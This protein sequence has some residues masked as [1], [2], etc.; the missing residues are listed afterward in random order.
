MESSGV[1]IKTGVIQRLKANFPEYNVYK[2]AI[3]KPVFPSFFIDI[4]NKTIQRDS[5]DRYFYTE[6]VNI[7]IRLGSD[8]TLINNINEQLDELLFKTQMILQEIY[9][10]GLAVFADL[11]SG[12]KSD[13]VGEIITNYRMRIKKEEAFELMRTLEDKIIIKEE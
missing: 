7:K 6:T 13:G 2:E 10:D 11:M 12:E 4:I 3:T 5:K 9:I 8:P 1:M